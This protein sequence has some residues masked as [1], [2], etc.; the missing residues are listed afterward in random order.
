MNETNAGSDRTLTA[1]PRGSA[2][3]LAGR[4]FNGHRAPLWALMC[5]VLAAA[6]IALVP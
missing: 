1:T 3:L 5:I 4:P 2:T 6:V